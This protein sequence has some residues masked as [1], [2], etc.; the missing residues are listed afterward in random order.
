MSI[1][2]HLGIGCVCGGGG[3]SQGIGTHI[4]YAVF[5]PIRLK[6]GNHLAEVVRSKPGRPVYRG[7]RHIRPP[8]WAFLGLFVYPTQRG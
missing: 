6:N 8:F 5:H 4:A 3:L 7:K 1:S 2:P